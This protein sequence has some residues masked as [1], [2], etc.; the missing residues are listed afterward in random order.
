MSYEDLYAVAIS[1]KYRHLSIYEALSLFKEFA[2]INTIEKVC[3]DFTLMCAST[4]LKKRIKMVLKN[5]DLHN[6]LLITIYHLP[7]EKN[8]R[9]ISLFLLIKALKKSLKYKYYKKLKTYYMK[10]FM[11]FVLAP[12]IYT[13]IEKKTPRV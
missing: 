1:S 10:T 8:L 12:K 11:K 9:D 3:Q 7:E 5:Y 2:Q 6:C 4:P 13:L